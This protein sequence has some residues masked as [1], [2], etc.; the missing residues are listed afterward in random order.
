MQTTI[1]CRVCNSPADFFATAR[2]L[3]KHDISYYHCK[4]C[5]FIQTESPYWLNEAYADAIIKSDIGLVSRNVSFCKHTK[6]LIN[7]V[8]NPNAKFVD[9]G[10]GYGMYVRLMRDAGFDFY[11]ADPHCQNLFSQGF[12]ATP[13][14]QYEALTAFEVFEHLA[15]P[16]QTVAEMLTYS[17]SIL[18]STRLMPNPPPNPDAHWYYALEGGQHVALYH[19][20]SLEVLA[21]RFGL[22]LATDGRGLHLMTPHRAATRWFKLALRPLLLR[23]F[24]WPKSRRSL[25]SRDYQLM[26]G[27][28]LT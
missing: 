3:G 12:D 15:E 24:K 11:R 27:K 26:T 7:T 16:V 18:F 25:L 2:I 6:L 19:Q 13:G 23:L 4:N 5:F 21:E 20:R 28:V 10:G 1:S 22:Y 14:T 8:F 9:Y 17:K